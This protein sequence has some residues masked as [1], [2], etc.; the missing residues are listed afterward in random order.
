MT[1]LPNAAIVLLALLGSGLLGQ[2]IRPLLRERHLSRESIDA[3]QVIVTMLVTFAALVLGLLTASVK[4]SFDATD[5]SMRG[6]AAA[7]IRLDAELRQYGPEADTARALLRRYTAAAINSTW[8]DEPPVAG[9]EAAPVHP[10][11]TDVRFEAS[12][13]GEILDQVEREI[14]ALPAQDPFHLRVQTDSIARFQSLV[15]LRWRLI[16]HAHSSLSTPFYIVLVF[17]LSVVFANLG[18]S[19]PRNALVYI[20]IIL[21]AVSIASVVLVLREFDTPFS[22]VIVVSSRPMHDA[23]AHLTR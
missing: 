17:W 8:T 14:H 16:E 6:F 4:N 10:A 18:L 19:A 3:V 22:G 23:L 13:L 11:A 2:L 9:A 1:N 7:I 21:G 12:P 5:E 15:D 20:T